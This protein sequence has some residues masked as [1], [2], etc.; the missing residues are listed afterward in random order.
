M[1]QHRHQHQ[2]REELPVAFDR[3]GRA[4]TRLASRLRRRQFVVGLAALSA[5]VLGRAWGAVAAQDDEG[6]PIVSTEV[7]DVPT[8]GGV[9]PG[10]VG[11]PAP[12]VRRRGVEPVAIQVP[13]IGL[14]AQTEVKEIVDGVMQDPSG[15]FVVSWYRETANLGDTVKGNTV[16]AGHVDYWNVGPAVFYEIDALSEGDEI[17]VIGEDG[18]PFTYEFQWIETYPLE[19]LTPEVIEEIVG[20]N[21]DQVL[22]LITCGGVFDTVSGEYLSRTVVRALLVDPV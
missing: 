20:P 22:T 2:D 1:D 14:D 3:T 19:E 11:E 7:G 10:P 16:M 13:V 6:Q 9:R 21:E 15:P 8:S 12:S 18:T 4:G 5:P 17:I